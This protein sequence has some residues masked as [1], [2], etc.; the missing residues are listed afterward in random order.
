MRV[1]VILSR[2]ASSWLVSADL[3]FG[4]AWYR[5][6]QASKGALQPVPG[7]LSHARGRLRPLVLQT[8][9]AS[10]LEATQLQLNMAAGVR[11]KRWLR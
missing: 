8:C 7:V 2:C 10:Q 1:E 4:V 3:D 9:S 5:D 6:H 11:S